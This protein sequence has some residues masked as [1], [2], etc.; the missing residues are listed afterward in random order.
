[1]KNMFKKGKYEDGWIARYLVF[2]FYN[3]YP[4]RNFFLSKSDY[5]YVIIILK[6]R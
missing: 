2:R 6:A 5:F 1:M 3:F 4:V